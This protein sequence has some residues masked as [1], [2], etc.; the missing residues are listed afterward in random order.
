MRSNSGYQAVNRLLM[1][2]SLF[3]VLFCVVVGST[4]TVEI[5]SRVFPTDISSYEHFGAS[6]A[7]SGDYLIVG[8]PDARYVSSRAMSGSAFYYTRSSGQFLQSDKT[9]VFGGEWKLG[10][11]VAISGERAVVGVP[12]DSIGM[13]I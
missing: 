12:H 8:A 7:M 6:C 10:R 2:V 11:S 13:A 4:P 5:S 3:F 1:S 9:G